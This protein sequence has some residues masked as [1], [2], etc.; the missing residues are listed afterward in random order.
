M[1]NIV[2]SEVA[3]GS[4]VLGRQRAGRLQGQF[5]LQVDDFHDLQLTGLVSPESSLDGS[6]TP[7]PGGGS[8]GGVSF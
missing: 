1:L 2:L 7:S 3:S 4:Y 5:L 8:F 6:I